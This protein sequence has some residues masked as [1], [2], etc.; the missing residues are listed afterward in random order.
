MPTL[1]KTKG[2]VIVNVGCGKRY[3]E[4]MVN[5]DIVALPGRKPPDVLA[6]ALHIPLPEG[7]ADEVMSIHNLEHI[8]VW[9]AGDAIDEWR[10]LLKPGGLLVLEMPDILKCCANML[11]GY[12]HSG[13]DPVQ[14]SYWGIFGDP[15]T[16][17]PFMMHKWG[18]HPGSLRELLTLH[19]MMHIAQEVP[20]W[21]PGGKDNRDFRMTAR[22]PT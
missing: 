7:C 20:Q 18:W 4:D 1:E 14:F 12:S 5:V 19:R 16:K 17:D 3:R 6:D 11:S 8:D 13:K 21:H 22:K 2:R 9:Q 10:R 15:T